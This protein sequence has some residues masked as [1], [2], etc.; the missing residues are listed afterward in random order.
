MFKAEVS[1]SSKLPEDAGNRFLQNTGMYIPAC[2]VSLYLENIIIL[3]R[4]T[5]HIKVH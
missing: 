1:S 5:A 4:I 3:V 2:K